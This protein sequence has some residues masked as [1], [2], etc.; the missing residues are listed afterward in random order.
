MDL[1]DYRTEED[2]KQKL[3]SEILERKEIQS[4]YYRKNRQSILQRVKERHLENGRPCKKQIRETKQKRALK[5]MISSCHFSLL[6]LLGTI[7]ELELD[8]YQSEFRFLT[9]LVEIVNNHLK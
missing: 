9:D 5:K 7:Q 1:T 4:E 2:K 6:P 8:V 3:P